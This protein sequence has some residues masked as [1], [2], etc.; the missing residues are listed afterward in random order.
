MPAI[1]APCAIV[2]AC[3]A[4]ASRAL[5]QDSAVTL[6]TVSASKSSCLPSPDT[7]TR[8]DG[9]LPRL[10]TST[11]SPDFPVMSP[12]A[13]RSVIAPSS[14]ASTAPV[15]PAGALT[16]SNRLTMIAPASCFVMSPDTTLISMVP[17]SF[18]VISIRRAVRRPLRHNANPK[19]HGVEETAPWQREPPSTGSRSWECPPETAKHRHFEAEHWVG[20]FPQADTG[21][22]NRPKA[23][24]NRVL[25]SL[26]SV[27]LSLS[28][29]GS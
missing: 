4:P 16:P 2:A 17:P 7:M 1:P 11:C 28:D 29:V 20:G 6:R 3:P 9:S 18:G 15:P 26:R 25:K 27:E 21:G 19:R 23:A 22:H 13:I 12:L 10:Y 5:R 24:T 14:A 8:G